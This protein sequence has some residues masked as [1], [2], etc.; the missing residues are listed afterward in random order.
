MFHSLVVLGQITLVIKL[1]LASFCHLVSQ[2]EPKFS[3]G[4]LDAEFAI[5]PTHTT[6]RTSLFEIYMPKLVCT[7]I[8]SG[9]SK[10]D[11]PV[12]ESFN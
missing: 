12:T 4:R 8:I 2:A 6:T 11:K 3:N 10:D 7:I 9:K 5:P 1:A